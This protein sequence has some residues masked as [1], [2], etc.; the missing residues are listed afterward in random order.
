MIWP[1]AT[2]VDPSVPWPVTLPSTACDEAG[3]TASANST[4]ATAAKIDFLVIVV[5][6]P[7]ASGFNLQKLDFVTHFWRE[8]WERIGGDGIGGCPQAQH[9]AHAY[10]TS[11][12]FAD[13]PCP[14][15]IKLH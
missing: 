6:P 5:K 3:I 2:G 14:E 9:T 10:A 1:P 12:I 15:H 7:E 13:V 4:A 11:S 8:V